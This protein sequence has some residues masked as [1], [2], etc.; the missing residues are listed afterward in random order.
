MAAY[1]LQPQSAL[2]IVVAAENIGNS[3]A[4]G[5]SRINHSY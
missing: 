5:K 4:L 3:K 2:G 1:Y